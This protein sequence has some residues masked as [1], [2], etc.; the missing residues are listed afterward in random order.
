MDFERLLNVYCAVID[1][2]GFTAAA[3]RLFLTQSAVS[4]YVRR[5]ELQ[6]SSELLVREGKRAYPTEAGEVIYQAAKDVS[7]VWSEA[8]VT[9]RELKGAEA[10]ASH[11]GASTPADFFLPP[12]IA[13]FSRQHP[14]TRVV[15]NVD[16]PERVSE[17][18]QRGEIDF[19]FVVAPVLPQGIVAEPVR[20]EELIV[21]AAPDHPLARRLS[22]ERS[23]LLAHNFVCA[24]AGT[25]MRTMIDEQLAA[26]GLE[27]RTVT[28]ELDSSQSAKL[29]VA[30]GGGLAILFR[31]AVEPDI[32]AGVL[33]QVHVGGLS[34]SHNVQLISRPKRRF[35]P[36]MRQ[37]MEFLKVQAAA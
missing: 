3:E 6:V 11:V 9:V 27:E 10:G 20:Q 14:K 16:R 26:I 37:L 8:L 15:L 4:Q 21:V 36:V 17:Q 29:A 25:Y 2:G 35:S 12:L 28:L 24:P 18:V 33:K 19:A 32:A 31:S 7:R 1:Y 22:V 13:R 23:E 30:G 5:L 34:L